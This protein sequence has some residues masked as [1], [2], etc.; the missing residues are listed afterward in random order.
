M[1]PIEAL[2]LVLAGVFIILGVMRG[3]LKELGL[4][5]VMIVWLFA[6]DQIIPRLEEWIRT[7]TPG[8]VLSTL[9]LTQATRDTPLWLL[10]TL[11]TVI[12]VYIAYQGETLAYEG[13]SPKGLQGFMLGVMI[14]AINGYLVCGTLWWILNRY[15]YP[16]RGLGLFIDYGPGMTLSPGANQIVN[17]L[18]LLP[19]DLLGQGADTPELQGVLPLLLISLVLLRVVR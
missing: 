14:G 4:T 10:F 2:W 6:L 9:G 19:P 15:N 18:K 11:G 5:T 12:V 16:V 17:G 8:S 13:T 3:F 1:G 7:A